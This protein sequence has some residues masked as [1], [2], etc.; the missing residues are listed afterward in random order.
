[1]A[2]AILNRSSAAC[3]TALVTCKQTAR[4]WSHGTS[5]RLLHL[6]PGAINMTSF[7][8]SLTALLAYLGRGAVPVDGMYF[9]EHARPAAA[10]CGPNGV[11]ACSA[12]AIVQQKFRAG[13]RVVM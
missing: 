9:L 8:K 2:S 10:S 3:E 7:L 13:Y 1:L 4:H 5:A 6:K 11:I 12:E